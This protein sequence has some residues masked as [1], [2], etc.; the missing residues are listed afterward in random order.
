MSGGSSQKPVTPDP[1]A[2]AQAQAGYN[3]DAAISQ[4]YLDRVNQVSPTGSTTWTV[5]GTNP[6]GTPKFT[7]TTA[8]TPEMQAINEGI[9][10]LA[11]KAVDN[12]GQAVNTPLNFDNAPKQI[13]N[14][15]SDL[16]GLQYK[17][18][19]IGPLATDFA[20][21]SYGRVSPTAGGNIQNGLDFSS[22]PKLAAY[23]DFGN[24]ANKYRDTVYSKLASRLD[25]QYNQSEA[26]MRARLAAQGISE[27]SDAYRRELDNFNRAK[28][29]AY[30]QANMD[31]YTQG[32]AE[33]SRLFGLS[34]AAR[35][36]ITG[37]MTTQG[38]FAN[39]AQGQRFDQYNAAQ[40]TNNAAQ[41]SQEQAALAAA[42]LANQ[43]ETTKFNQQMSNAQFNNETQ[44]Q[45]F[46]QEA[47]NAA[48]NNSGRT[49][50]INETMALHETPIQDVAAL[51]GN[52]T[53]VSQAPQFQPVAQVGV[54][55]PDYSNLVENQYNQQ[56]A[57][58]NQE[59][60]N[61]GS[62]LGGIFGA[63]GKLGGAIAASDKR[64]KYDITPIGRLA[65][66]LR[67][68]T[69]K[70]IGSRIP[71]FGV[72]AQEVFDIMPEAVVIRKDG[73]MMVDYSKV[74]A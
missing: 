9:Q 20:R 41:A 71:Q 40:Q 23:D 30:E 16:P 68:Y 12:A 63:V 47:A 2:T 59:Q 50:A 43:A 72:M 57:M 19:D 24:D 13:T 45:G 1:T 60:Q 33:Q 73:L 8:L 51:T 56:V 6:D 27:N 62:A 49:Q 55:A 65:N 4:A 25:P 42:N 69:F 26:D 5:T 70:Y 7:E 61:K 3:K 64:S 53:S 21:S 66:G 52:S 58:Y 22:A 38:N 11:G 67:T 54:A 48:L 35:D 15:G 31:A 28:T 10:K 34:K 17:G 74:Y 14:V 37:E 44:A 18:G 32:S 36:T 29:D 39:N 46:N